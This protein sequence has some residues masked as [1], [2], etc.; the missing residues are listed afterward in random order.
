LGRIADNRFALVLPGMKPAYMI[1]ILDRIREI[2]IESGTAVCGHRIELK[3]GGS[4]YP[5]N[6]D[7]ARN[8][9]AVGEQKLDGP[10]PRWEESLRALLRVGG[11]AAADNMTEES[12]G[13]ASHGSRGTVH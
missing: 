2:A 6:G 3:L 4:F 7:G 12:S 8:L 13:V 10:N 11:T 1:A 5:D 9:L